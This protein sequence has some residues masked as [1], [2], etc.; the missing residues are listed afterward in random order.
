MRICEANWRK[1]RGLVN[2]PEITKPQLIRLKRLL[3]V[4]NKQSGDR[5]QI[6]FVDIKVDNFVHTLSDEKIFDEKVFDNESFFRFCYS[7]ERRARS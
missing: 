5:C 4:N 1:I 7:G 6:E 2:R 3:P